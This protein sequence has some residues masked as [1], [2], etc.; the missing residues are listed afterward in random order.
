M[1]RRLFTFF[2][3]LS[4]LL[5]LATI[6]LW[7]RSYRVRDMV[8]FAKAGGNSH[9]A[10]SILGRV[11]VQ[12]TFG[13]STGGFHYAADRLSPQAIWNGG[14][15]RY[16]VNTE[17]HFGFVWQSYSRRHMPLWGNATNLITRHRLI[18]V[19][20]WSVSVLLAV[21]PG[22]WVVGRLRRRDR[23]EFGHC[24]Q[25]GYDLRASPE[26]CPECATAIEN[27]PVAASHA[28]IERYLLSTR[29]EEGELL[30]AT[31]KGL[32]VVHGSTDSIQLWWYKRRRELGESGKTIGGFYTLR[33]LGAT[34]FG[35]RPGCSISE[36]KRWLGHRASSQMADVHMKP[37]TPETRE[38]IGFVREALATGEVPRPNE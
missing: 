26:R 38:A 13:N 33:H 17:W 27:E 19:P 23:V 20:Y 9:M 25:C 22:V 35:S 28:T 29:R 7:L 1:I 36:V 37:V 6:V 8:S 16:P 24:R 10:Q 32:P 2:S 5:C 4:L 34:E 18:V 3:V 11:H 21:L 15:S 12:T 31:R 30:F 14:M